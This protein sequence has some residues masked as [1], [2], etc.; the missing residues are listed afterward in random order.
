LLED[1][2][3]GLDRRALPYPRPG[4]VTAMR[5]MADALRRIPVTYNDK[6]LG[7]SIESSDEVGVPAIGHR[8]AMMLLAPPADE[9]V[10][11][12]MVKKLK[13]PTRR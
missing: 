3:Q 2:M 13:R 12:R 11:S 9:L 1:Y 8:S 4:W 5:F 6:T 7:L 10:I